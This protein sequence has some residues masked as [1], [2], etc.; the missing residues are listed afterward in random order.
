M[1]GHAADGGAVTTQPEALTVEYLFPTDGVTVVSLIGE[2][3]LATA[4]LARRALSYAIEDDPPTLVL[5]LGETTFIDSTG[6][7][8]IY[9][10]H[11]RRRRKG[12]DG[13]VLVTNEM[14]QRLF[15]IAGVDATFA[16]APD[17]DAVLRSAAG[18]RPN[19]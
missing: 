15:E 8:A 2:F 13:V 7:R 9:N 6:L 16:I 1:N 3:D 14:T 10:A 12:H 19:R 5:D 18:G 4:A 17:L 11:A